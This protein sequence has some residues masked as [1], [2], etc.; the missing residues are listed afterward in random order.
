MTDSFPFYI[1]NSLKDNTHQLGYFSIKD[2]TW[3]EKYV[4]DENFTY[5]ETLRNISGSVAF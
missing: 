4:N 1:K 5:L 3:E 2:L